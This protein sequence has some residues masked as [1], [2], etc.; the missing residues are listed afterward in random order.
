MDAKIFSIDLKLGVICRCG[1]LFKKYGKC[2]SAYYI[3]LYPFSF[4]LPT[5]YANVLGA[6]EAGRFGAVSVCALLLSVRAWF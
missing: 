2:P 5:I 1:T 4:L 6:N 3:I